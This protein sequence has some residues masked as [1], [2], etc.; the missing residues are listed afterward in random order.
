MA[1]PDGPRDRAA[2]GAAGGVSALRASPAIARGPVRVLCD[3]I[4]FQFSPGMENPRL[5]VA[6][7]RTLVLEVAEIRD[8]AER[9]KDVLGR[10]GPS[11]G[12]GQMLNKVLDMLNG[13]DVVAMV[14]QCAGLHELAHQLNP[15]DAYP[16]D[17]LIDMLSSCVSGIRFGCDTGRWGVG[18]RHAAEAAQHVWGRKYGVSLFDAH[19]PRWQHDWTRHKL[20]EALISLA[21]PPAIGIAARSDETPLGGSGVA[22]PVNKATDV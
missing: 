4:G 3:E 11:A 1:M 6:F 20:R 2:H 16:T 18:S 22:H 5:L 9:L 17:H 13:G 7:I 21:F 14:E 8:L 15:D 10:D 19:T 12:S